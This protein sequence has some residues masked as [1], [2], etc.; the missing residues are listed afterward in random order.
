MRA[1]LVNAALVKHGCPNMHHELP[2][3]QTAALEAARAA[4][5]NTRERAPSRPSFTFTSGRSDAGRSAA[6]EAASQ[7][8]TRAVLGQALD[9]MASADVDWQV[10]ALLL[11]CGQRQKHAPIAQSGRSQEDGAGSAPARS[12][13][14][15]SSSQGARP[16]W[17]DNMLSDAGAR[18]VMP[19]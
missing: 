5:Q 3:A 4:L 1:A 6:A 14:G 8:A 18:R 15:V 9:G 17:T 10:R 13:D 2:C 12:A 16:A 11:A 19:A 7:E